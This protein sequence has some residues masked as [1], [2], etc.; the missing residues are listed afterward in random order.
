MDC[1]RP[2]EQVATQEETLAA[3]QVGDDSPGLLDEQGTRRQI[4]GREA[5]FEEAVEYPHR[6]VGQVDR[7]GPTAPDRAG[8][9]EDPAKDL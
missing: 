7:R 2:S 5:E 1:G 4:P 3:V 9:G 8:P 6:R